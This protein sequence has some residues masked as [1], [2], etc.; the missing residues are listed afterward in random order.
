[1][2]A[3]AASVSRYVSVAVRAWKLPRRFL[4]FH[5]V[6]LVEELSLHVSIT[7]LTLTNYFPSMP[8]SLV[9]PFY[10]PFHS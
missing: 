1:M 2:K 9:T 10:P 8:V 5:L 6:S 4:G 3:P 7:P